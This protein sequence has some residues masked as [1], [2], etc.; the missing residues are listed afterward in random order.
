[1]LQLSLDTPRQLLHYWRIE[2]VTRSETAA[3]L[4][5]LTL[6]LDGRAVVDLGPATGGTMVEFRKRGARCSFIERHPACYAAC[7]LRGFPGVLGDF[8]AKPSLL[9]GEPL[10]IVYARG[11][12]TGWSWQEPDQ[13]AAW[14]LDLA[15]SRVACICP[16]R[17]F[18]GPGWMGDVFSECG[19]HP[20]QVL[21]NA[22]PLYPFT[23]LYGVERV[24]GIGA[25]S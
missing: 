3:L 11:S 9:L 2:P 1:M 10:D 4:D 25:A 18:D 17:P 6:E 13:L 23:W 14:L 8:L 22:T 21:G 19:F 5:A 16:Y 12:V 20:V 7:R 15:R 24:T